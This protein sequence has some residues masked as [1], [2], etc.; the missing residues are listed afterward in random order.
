MR[1]MRALGIGGKTPVA[2]QKEYM[3]KMVGD[4]AA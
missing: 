3:K 1:I 2:R 4:N